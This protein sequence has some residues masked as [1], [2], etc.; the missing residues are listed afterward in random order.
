[1][2]TSSSI[3]PFPSLR[4]VLRV[5]VAEQQLLLETEAEDDVEAVGRRVR[6]DPDQRRPGKVD[7]ALEGLERPVREDR[8]AVTELRVE[9]PP[10]GE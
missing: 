9:P 1:M 8:E 5:E 2:P 3:R 6:V 7:R 10:E 4:Q